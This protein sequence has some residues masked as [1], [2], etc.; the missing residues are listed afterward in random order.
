M[1]MTDSLDLRSYK[2]YD[3]ISTDLTFF[4]SIQ[5][6]TVIWL[7]KRLHPLAAQKNELSNVARHV[8]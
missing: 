6:E 2:S 5:I 3:P 4:D 8:G 1:A 7:G